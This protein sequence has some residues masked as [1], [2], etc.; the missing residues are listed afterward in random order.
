[1][2]G[3]LIL[4]AYRVWIIEDKCSASLFYWFGA[5]FHCQETVNAEG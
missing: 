5:Y 4:A 3:D 2:V 1:M